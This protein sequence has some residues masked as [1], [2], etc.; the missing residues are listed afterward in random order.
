M[1]QDK[2]F[3]GLANIGGGAR[4]TGALVHATVLLQPTKRWLTTV[5]SLPVDSSGK[6]GSSK[7]KAPKKVV[8][9][10]LK[11]PKYRISNV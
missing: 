5:C 8:K 7:T 1:A 4:P 10:A 3:F 9:K 11:N 2:K 6:A